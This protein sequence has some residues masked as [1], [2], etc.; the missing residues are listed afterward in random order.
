M[1]ILA[2]I[3]IVF[4]SVSAQAKFK[5][6]TTEMKQSLS[7]GVVTCATKV[8]FHKRAHS[9]AFILSKPVAQLVQPDIL[10]I[11]YDYDFLNCVKSGDKYVWKLADVYAKRTYQHLVPGDAEWKTARQVTVTVEVKDGHLVAIN[12]A[13]KPVATAELQSGVK[14][15]TMMLKWKQLASP[16]QLSELERGETV[17][18]RTEVFVQSRRK[19]SNSDGVKTK[20]WQ[21]S[22]RGSYYLHIHLKKVSGRPVVVAVY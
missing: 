18:L 2:L 3:A 20:W 21:Q 15:Y 11:E 9:G 10:E 19:V 7:G 5:P 1:K 4:F 6:V 12:E 13:Y 8:D 22:S 17:R 14:R 16:Q